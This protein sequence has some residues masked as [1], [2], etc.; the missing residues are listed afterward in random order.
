MTNDLEII[1][2]LRAKVGKPPLTELI[3]PDPERVQRA[4]E[5]LEKQILY[6]G[7]FT[8]EPGQKCTVNG[9]GDLMMVKENGRFLNKDCVIVKR[10]RNG[11]LMIAL[12]SNPKIRDVFAQYNVSPRDEQCETC[13]IMEKEND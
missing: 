5:L 10:C 7:G 2:S 1:N 12:E 13:S 4:K 9:Y 11:L 6:R 3:N 8:Y